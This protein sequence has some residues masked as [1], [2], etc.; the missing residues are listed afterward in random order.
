[1]EIKYF[2]GDLLTSTAPII[3]HQ[4]NCLGSMKS[5]VA[6]VISE[7]W[8]IVNEKYNNIYLSW[9]IHMFA[10]FATNTIGFILFSK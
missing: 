2:D 10:N 9:L 4:C 6:K 8:P 7:K 3:M 1:M 5:G